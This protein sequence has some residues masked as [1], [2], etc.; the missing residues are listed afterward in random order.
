MIPESQKQPCYLLTGNLRQLD[1]GSMIREALAKPE[2]AI[3]R[4]RMGF[5]D[6]FEQE[7]TSIPLVIMRQD[8]IAC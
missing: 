5:E 8:N 4:S 6:D 7:N 1:F 2:G 3:L